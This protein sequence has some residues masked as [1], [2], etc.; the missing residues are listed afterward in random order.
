MPHM[1]VVHFAQA[2]SQPT[3]AQRNRVAGCS[4]V[5]DLFALRGDVPERQEEVYVRGRGG[6]RVWAHRNVQV[7][8][9]MASDLSFRLKHGRGELDQRWIFQ[10]AQRGIAEF[11]VPFLGRCRD[12]FLLR[13]EVVPRVLGASDWPFGLLA[14]RVCFLCFGVVESYIS[15][16]EDE[17]D[18]WCCAC[19]PPCAVL[20]LQEG[21]QEASLEF[22]FFFVVEG[23][24][25]AAGDETQVFEFAACLRVTFDITSQ[26]Q[27]NATPVG[28]GQERD[29][30]SRQHS[31]SKS[32]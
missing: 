5:E 32:G 9:N 21:I 22:D 12:Q 31:S 17:V 8:Y 16:A 1:L 18:C 20:A 30:F 11:G 29:L 24:I 27:E 23:Q 14:T 7:G 6:A 26:M 25:V 28:Y 15:F 4:G 3:L 2:Y 10:R 13:C 19:G